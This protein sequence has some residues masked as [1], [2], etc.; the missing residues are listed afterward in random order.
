MCQPVG[1]IAV[2]AGAT[3]ASARA[4]ATSARVVATSAGA[5]AASTR[6]VFPLLE[7]YMFSPYIILVSNRL[8]NW[9]LMKF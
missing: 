9:Y 8:A 5:V 7:N 1:A 4:V 6:V 3:V 2:A